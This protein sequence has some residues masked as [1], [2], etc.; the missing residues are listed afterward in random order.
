MLQVTYNNPWPVKVLL[1]FSALALVLAGVMTLVPTTAA[2]PKLQQAEPCRYFPETGFQVCGR[3]LEYWN[4]NGGLAQQG[5]PISRVFEEQNAA[6]PAGDG[7]LH[8]VQYFQRSRFESHPDNNAPFDVLLGLLG[9]EQF[10]TKYGTTPV[11]T[12]TPPLSGNLRFSEIKGAA[13]GSYASAAVQSTAGAACSLRYIMPN[14]KN[15]LAGGLGLKTA[16]QTGQVIWTWLINVDTLPGQGLLYVTCNNET[17]SA[18][19]QIV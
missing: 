10:M 18:P 12:A 11:P 14:G 1:E 7:K 4:N 16:D 2:R 3:F 15:S 6:P 8:S 9:T 13:P 19:I 5:L 17:F